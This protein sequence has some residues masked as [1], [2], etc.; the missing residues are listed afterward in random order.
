MVSSLLKIDIG[1][2]LPLYRKEKKRLKKKKNQKE[3]HLTMS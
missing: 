1:N 2:T 3:L